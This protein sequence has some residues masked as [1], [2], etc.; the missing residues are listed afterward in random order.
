MHLNDIGY[1]VSKLRT[2]S[3]IYT[4]EQS[5]VV[6]DLTDMKNEVISEI[7]DLSPE[8][9]NG[10]NG[11][12]KRMEKFLEE[13]D[14]SMDHNYPDELTNLFAKYDQDWWESTFANLGCRISQRVILW[15]IGFQMAYD[16]IFK[17]SIQEE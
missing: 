17:S 9:I 12:F 7:P 2:S 8:E 11:D 13:M 16:Q 15:A 3:D 1:Y 6:E 14:L 5:D 4:Y 10:I